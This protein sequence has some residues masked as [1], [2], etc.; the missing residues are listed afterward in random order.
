MLLCP[1]GE[2]HIVKKMLYLDVVFKI[3]DVDF[4]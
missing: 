4:F 3:S 2:K 1:D